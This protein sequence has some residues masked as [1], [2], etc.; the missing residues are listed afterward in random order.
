MCRFHVHRYASKNGD[1]KSIDLVEV[2][3]LA[4][5]SD[6]RFEFAIYKRSGV[7]HTFRAATREQFVSWTGGLQSY[8]AMAQAYYTL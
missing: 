8:V 4:I 1:T 2:D 5:V 6:D 7:H 3:R